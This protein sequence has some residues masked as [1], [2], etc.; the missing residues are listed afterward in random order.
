MTDDFLL[1]ASGAS[2][3]LTAQLVESA[4]QL[5]VAALQAIQVIGE[6]VPLSALRPEEV[7]MLRKAVAA[8]HGAGRDIRLIA[9]VVQRRAEGQFP[10]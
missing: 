5:E 10:R 8:A 1:T 6:D 4:E 9:T 3:P 7:A 2:F